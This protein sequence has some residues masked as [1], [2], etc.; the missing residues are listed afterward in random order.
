MSSDGSCQLV[1]QRLTGRPVTTD[2]RQLYLSI[3]RDP[4]VAHWIRRSGP[5]PDSAELKALDQAVQHWQDHGIGIW[6]FFLRDS[7]QLVGRGGLRH[8]ELEGCAEVELLYSLP[9]AQWRRGYATEM[10]RAALEFGHQ[11]GLRDVVAFT[12]PH[13]RASRRVMEKCEFRFEREFQHADQQHVL[14]RLTSPPR[15]T[16]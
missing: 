9:E 3:V 1:T 10:S 14:Y 7:G 5:Q 13:N 2:D 6:V 8:I 12:L 15:E 4:G 11:H 16:S